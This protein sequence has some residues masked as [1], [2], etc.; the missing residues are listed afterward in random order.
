MACGVLDLSDDF[1][2]KRQ[3]LLRWENVSPCQ[4]E[5]SKS[6]H[7]CS[8]FRVPGAFSSSSASSTSYLAFSGI[9]RMTMAK[10]Q[11]W[12]AGRT[13]TWCP[14]CSIS[15]GLIKSSDLM[16]SVRSK[17]REQTQHFRLL[18]LVSTI[19]R[20]P[21]LFRLWLFP[22]RLWIINENTMICI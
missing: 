3:H 21:P 9:H 8:Y 22:L 11:S 5:N 10:I 20:Y 16:Q 12:L 19:R 15:I 13:T 4:S 7:Q 17:E 2:G 1:S 6:Q 18:G 14:H